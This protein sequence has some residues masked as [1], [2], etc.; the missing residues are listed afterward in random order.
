MCKGINAAGRRVVQIMST[1]A[2]QR[3]AETVLRDAGN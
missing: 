2:G 3:E 1:G